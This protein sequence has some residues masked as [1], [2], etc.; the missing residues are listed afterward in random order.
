M[1]LTF[2]WKT[3]IKIEVDMVQKFVKINKDV[4]LYIDKIIF[5]SYFPIIFTCKDDKNN[6]YMCVCCQ[7]NEKGIKWLVGKTDSKSIVKVL[8]DKITIREL[9]LHNTEEHI[10]IEYINGDYSVEYNNSDWK[11]NSIYLPKKDSYIYADEGEFDEEIKYFQSLDL[12]CYDEN[13]YV[14]VSDIQELFE[15]DLLYEKF[16]NTIEVSGKLSVKTADLNS[17]YTDSKPIRKILESDLNIIY[18]SSMCIDILR[19]SD[20][21]TDAA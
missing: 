14:G 18:D 19:N 8:E 7:N 1:I 13:E 2:I 5:E 16:T 21:N 6:I 11:E 9:L 12:I 10:S 17:K 3:I 4:Q 15:M 20:N